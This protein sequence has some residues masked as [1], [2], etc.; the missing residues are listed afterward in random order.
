MSL[1][2][3]KIR[4]SSAHHDDAHSHKTILLQLEKL[5]ISVFRVM[6]TLI[7]LDFLVLNY[8]IDQKDWL[9][10]YSYLLYSE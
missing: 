1:I 2:S 4:G 5:S 9:K 10:S 3:F 6:M 8:D 7:S